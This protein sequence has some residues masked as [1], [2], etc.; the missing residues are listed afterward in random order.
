M[1]GI[2]LVRQLQIRVTRPSSTLNIKDGVTEWLFPVILFVPNPEITS[3]VPT[4]TC[5]SNRKG[6]NKKSGPSQEIAANK[7][8]DKVVFST[9]AQDV[10]HEAG[11]ES[12]DYGVLS[13]VSTMPPGQTD[14]KQ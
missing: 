7:V 6:G 13:F 14:N 11:Y 10:R 1:R 3:L 2:H 8:F 5:W 12:R 4:T 9:A